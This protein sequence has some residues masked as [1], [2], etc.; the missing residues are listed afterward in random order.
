MT[1]VNLYV[2]ME[3]ELVKESSKKAEAKMAQESS[4]KRAGDELEQEPSKKQNME[5]DKETTQLQS[6]M[7]V[8]P[9]EEE[10]ALMY[11]TFGY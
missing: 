5:D 6:I 9:D 7:E 11:K 2:D 10:V 8:I 1:R 3:I 4:S